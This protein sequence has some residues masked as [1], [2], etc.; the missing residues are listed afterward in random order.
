MDTQ[1]FTANSALI[2]LDFQNDIVAEKGKLSGKGYYDFSQRY[3]SL[4]NVRLLQNHFRQLR[5]PVIHVKVGFSANYCEQ[6]KTSPIMGKA[7]QF[8]ALLLNSWGTEFVEDVKPIN[9]EIVIIKHRIS[10]FHQTAL[11]LILRQQGIEQIVLAGAATDMAVESTARA[12]HDLDFKLTV[13]ADACISANDED[14]KRT[15]TVLNKLATV[16]NTDSVIAADL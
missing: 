4:K 8:K 6:P 14:H 12:G 11:E 13:V 7:D 15:L 1:V 16:I 2:C 9:D 10:G 3:N 5:R